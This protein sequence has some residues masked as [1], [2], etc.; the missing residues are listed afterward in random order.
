MGIGSAPLNLRPPID[1]LLVVF[2]LIFILR[3][4]TLVLISL[5]LRIQSE[6][7]VVKSRPD[8]AFWLLLYLF[9]CE[10]NCQFRTLGHWVT[11]FFISL[12]VGSKAI[13]GP[14]LLHVYPFTSGVSTV[15]FQWSHVF[16][17]CLW[18]L[19]SSGP[20]LIKLPWF[21]PA[22]ILLTQVRSKLT[23]LSFLLIHLYH[24]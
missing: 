19:H 3:S 10:G 20:P 5:D 14:T 6:S 23:R 11:S 4:A 15:A 24:R 9:S 12:D 17:F 16:N 22:Q 2:F 1:Y 8:Q 21:L 13:I 7:V 18:M